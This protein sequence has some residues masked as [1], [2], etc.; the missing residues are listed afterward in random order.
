MKLKRTEVST[1]NT[2]IQTLLTTKDV[3]NKKLIYSLVKNT[4]LLEVEV[5]SIQKAYDTNTDEYTEFVDALRAIYLKYG[6]A[7]AEGNLITTDGGNGFKLKKEGDAKKLE[8]EIATLEKKY[9]KALKA[10]EAEVETYK[11]FLA[12]EVEIDL[13]KIAFDDLPDDMSAQTMYI[14]DELIE[15]P[16]N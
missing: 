13:V 1:I 12:E 2:A 8:K 6:E 4:K 16:K 11:T 15:A 9:E 14:L 3:T 7:D 5:E 10:R